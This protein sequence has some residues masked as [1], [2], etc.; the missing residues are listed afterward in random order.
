VQVVAAAGNPVPCLVFDEVDVGVG[1]AVAE[2]VGRRLRQLAADRQVLCVTHLP[3]V[4]AQAS[5]HLAVRK[6][7]EAGRAQT[8]VAPLDAG[9]RVEEL[10][11]MLGGLTIT[12][13]TRANA[14]EMLREA[15]AG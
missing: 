12:E 15:A 7:I 11:R 1:G 9:A 6:R 10:A 8:E 4:A 13:R 14:R 5:G 2:I 3:Q